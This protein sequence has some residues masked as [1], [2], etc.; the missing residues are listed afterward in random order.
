MIDVPNQLR[1]FSKPTNISQGGT[2]TSECLASCL[3]RRYRMLQGS[4]GSRS[5][6]ALRK[7]SMSRE[8]EP[9]NYD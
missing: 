9:Y 2:A 7:A 8:M 4:N 6:G 5:S 3:G 1:R